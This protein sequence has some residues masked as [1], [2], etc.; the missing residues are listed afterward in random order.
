LPA[1]GGLITEE[2]VTQDSGPEKLIYAITP[3]GLEALAGWLS[4]PVEG[5][6]RRDEFFLKLMLCLAT[7]AADPYQLIYTWFVRN[8]DSGRQLRI[9]ACRTATL[10]VSV[11]DTI[12]NLKL[13][14][15]LECVDIIQEVNLLMSIVETKKLTKVYGKD[16]TAV[17]AL[18]DV[19]LR[20]EAGEFVAVMGPSGCGKS[21]LLHMI[22]GLDRP[23]SGS[24]HFENNDL[25]QL[26]DNAL[27]EVRR[28]KIGFIFQFYN[29]IPVLGAV[30]NAALPLILDGVKPAKAYAQA[31]EWLKRF[32]MQER[33][34]HRPDQ[35]SGGQQQKVAIARALVTE[36]A[37]ILADEP[38]GNLDSLAADDIVNL[39]RQIANEWGRTILMVTHNPRLSAYADR[40]IFLKDGSVV[41]D[42]YISGNGQAAEKAVQ[43]KVEILGG[44]RPPQSTKFGS[45]ELVQFSSKPTA[46]LT[47]YIGRPLTSS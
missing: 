20:L 30:E 11:R 26:N 24:V 41:D 3:N 22:G 2:S 46:S 44:Y 13:T 47:T 7:G 43:R 1:K 39:L 10:V 28:R 27:T 17:S 12:S 14:R 31:T 21:T 40:I 18:N 9:T 4:A 37:L 6:H 35:L 38:T 32:E 5:Q 45:T 33:S 25:T 19:N 42:T 29:L 36:P 8:S 34:T 16:E 15:I 23:T